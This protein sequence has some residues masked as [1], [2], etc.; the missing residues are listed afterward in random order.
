MHLPW[1]YACLPDAMR[2]AT[3]KEGAIVHNALASYIHIHFLA[4]PHAAQRFVAAA[5]AFRH[6]ATV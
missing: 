1:L 3:F 2:P 6:G 5:A 4:C